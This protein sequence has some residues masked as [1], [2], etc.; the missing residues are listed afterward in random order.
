MKKKLYQIN[1]LYLPKDDIDVSVLD[2]TLACAIV[3]ECCDLDESQVKWLNSLR[4][5]RNRVSEDQ[6]QIQWDI[7]ETAVIGLAGNVG[8]F[9]KKE[10]KK[11]IRSIQEE[12]STDYLK[13][14]LQETDTY[15]MTRS[16]KQTLLE[17]IDAENVVLPAIHEADKVSALNTA[18]ES[19]GIIRGQFTNSSCWRVGQNFI[20]TVWHGIEQQI[21]GHDN[22]MNEHKLKDMTVEFCN[23]KRFN[24]K[25]SIVYQSKEL[26]TVVLQIDAAS[27]NL[28]PPFTKFAIVDPEKDD[29]ALVHLIAYSEKKQIHFDVELWNPSLTRIQ[30]L[31]EFCAS[32]YKIIENYDNDYDELLHKNRLVVK[33]Q[34]EHGA[35]GCP[36]LMLTHNNNEPHVVL[37]FAR[38]FPNFYYRRSFAR[39]RRKF[40]RSKLF[41]QGISLCSIYN[42]IKTRNPQLCEQIFE[43]EIVCLF[44]TLKMKIHATEPDVDDISSGFIPANIETIQKILCKLH[45]EHMSFF[46]CSHESII[47][48]ECVCS[49]HIKCPDILT[50]TRAAKYGLSSLIDSTEQKL[51]G[52]NKNV[53]FLMQKQITILKKI[54]KQW[55]CTM[56]GIVENR[57]SHFDIE[58]ETEKDLKGKRSHCFN[59]VK[60]ITRELNE[61]KQ[62]IDFTSQDL[63]NKKS[64]EKHDQAFCHLH[65]I[66]LELES[67]ETRLNHIQCQVFQFNWISEFKK[68]REYV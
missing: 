14:I 53:D 8:E 67:I 58:T 6:F 5:V 66:K 12:F 15:R 46:C 32:K 19:V 27:R 31:K 22:K 42:D 65:D 52:L 38:G 35:S 55:C 26:D 44:K 47:C 48:V 18:S 1:H 60:N 63:Q 36:G 24:I 16:L 40:P 9:F 4:D 54:D 37:M 23:K 50:V 39:E 11:Q 33:C 25:P 34:F 45:K 2:I 56:R 68:N 62:K 51:N 59:H 43:Y 3:R 57:T 49:N 10:Q 64:I 30:S 61:I 29:G 13:D 28:P 41:Q 21:R 20:M 7:L 17:L